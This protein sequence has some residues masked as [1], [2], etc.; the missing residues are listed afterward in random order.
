[1]SDTGNGLGPQIT[2]LAAVV[3][4]RRDTRTGAW[5]PAAKRHPLTDQALQE[6]YHTAGPQ[7]DDTPLLVKRDDGR[8][9]NMDEE[10]VFG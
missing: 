5:N 9:A 7:I 3:T 4:F 2:I 6:I 10:E 8:A 1:M